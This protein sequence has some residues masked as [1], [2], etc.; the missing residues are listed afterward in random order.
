VLLLEDQAALVTDELTLAA[1]D[2]LLGLTLR[3]AADLFVFLLFGLRSSFT[4]A[5]GP[6]HYTY[7]DDF[8]LI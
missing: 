1:L 5:C 4:L 7:T 6:C 2:E 8:E 3:T